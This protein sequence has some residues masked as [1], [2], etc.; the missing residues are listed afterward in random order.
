MSNIFRDFAPAYW[1]AGLPVM[2]L[3]QRD[4]RPILHEWQQYSSN[5]P[6][7]GVQD[8]WLQEYPRSN[9]GLPFGTASGLCAIDIDT[10]DETQ[11]KA[12]MSV[13]PASPWV[14]VGKKGCAIAFKWQG[15]RNFKI[16]DSANQSIVEFLGQGN[17]LVLPPSI[18][19]DTGAAYVANSNLWEVLGDIPQ[20]GVDI[21]DRLR[22]A[23]GVAGFSLSHEG[24]SKPLDVV[25]SGERDIQLVRHAGYLSRVVLGIDKQSR[26]SLSEAMNQMDYWVSNFT[27][28]SAGD[29]MD[30]DKGVAKLLEF[31]LK[32]LEGGR[33]L[34]EGWDADLTQDQLDHPTI[35][36][37][38]AKNA[39]EAWSVT[40]ARDWIGQQIA[41]KPT[42]DDWALARVQELIEKVAADENFTLFEF[43]A[44]CPTLETCSSVKFRKTDLVKLFKDTR[45]AQKELAADHEAIAR[46][47]I[48]DVSRTGELRWWFGSFWQWNG[49]C[50]KLLDDASIKEHVAKNVKGNTLA[51]REGDYSSITKMVALLSRQPLDEAGEVGV[52]FA[53]GFLDVAGEL[54]EH[55]PKFGK[56]FTM[57]FNYV[58]A[59]ATEA[60]KWIAFLDSC[61]GKDADRD[62]KVMALQEAFGVTMFGLGPKHQRAILLHGRGASGKSTALAVLQEMMP[63]DTTAVLPPQKWS[64]RFALT[65]L[66]NKALNICGELPESATIDGSRFKGIV[67]G[68]DQDTEYK[69]RDGFKFRPYATHWFASNHLPRSRD[70]SDA[71]IRR[72]LVLDFNRVIPVAERIPNFAEI[73]IAEE[74]EAIAA[75]AVEGLMR[76]ERDGW[77]IPPSHVVRESQI[78]RSNNSVAAFLQ[79]CDRVTVNETHGGDCREI[80]D[81]YL[82]YMRDVSRGMGVTFE[83]FKVMLEDLGFVTSEYRDEMRTTRFKVDGVGLRHALA[84]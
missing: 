20:L 5:M 53:N 81:V 31:L 29:D 62:A 32:D 82:L 61:W 68:E 21:E 16:R 46:E 77:T 7:E 74:R 47:V 45:D 11:T 78:M 51:K 44:L 23:L 1:A 17:Q 6:S 9:I 10:L 64:E 35:N 80:F 30:P 54:H 34:P 65:A 59:R 69:G 55:D 14:R 27:A 38:A 57:P 52:N 41:M 36:A 63:P 2:P 37:I 73:L 56:T 43:Q 70:T 26:F 39:A 18:H 33:T 84:A 4:K 12:I 49:S 22:A 83:R 60:H 19:P 79:S 13:L 72:W 24:R 8:H 50:F 66:V 25:P 58:P 48:E 3:K 75:W 15:Q 28:R 42:D 40:R 71:F 67:V 76:I